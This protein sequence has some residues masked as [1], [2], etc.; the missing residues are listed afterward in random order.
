MA[1]D[2]IASGHSYEVSRVGSG[3]CFYYGYVYDTLPSSTL[4]AACGFLYIKMF[5]YN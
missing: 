1:V 2:E 5:S 3:F 4:A